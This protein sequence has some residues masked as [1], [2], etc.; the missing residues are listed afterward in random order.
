MPAELRGNI[1]ARGGKRAENITVQYR[2]PFAVNSGR[3]LIFIFQL[4]LFPIKTIWKQWHGN[5][6]TCFTNT[7][8]ILLIELQHYN[9]GT[10]LKCIRRER[11]SRRERRQS[12]RS[13][14]EVGSGSASKWKL[15]R[16]RKQMCLEREERDVERSREQFGA[17]DRT[18]RVVCPELLWAARVT[19]MKAVN[20]LNQCSP[21]PS[22]PVPASSKGHENRATSAVCV[23]Y[24]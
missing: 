9:L 2:K 17:W 24:T 10:F 16:V 8:D 4:H 12:R 23:H 1:S 5:S 14:V 6:L 20:L 3:A 22:G 15:K 13:R 19:R 18:L 21:P 7:P 11:Q